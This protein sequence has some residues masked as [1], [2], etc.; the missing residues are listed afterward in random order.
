MYDQLKKLSMKGVMKRLGAGIV[1][2]LIILFVA[3]QSFLKLAKGPQDLYQ[4]TVDQLPNSY[5]E[6]DINVILGAYA[7]YY[8][9]NDDGTEEVTDN[10]YI[11]PVGEEEFVGLAVNKEDF[12]TADQIYNE[13]Y[14]YMMGYRDDLSTSMKV[15]GT[16]NKME[17]DVYEFYEEWFMTSGI[18]ENPTK[19]EFERVALPYVLEID[20]VGKLDTY[21]V[22]LLA[23]LSVILVL[24]MLYAFIA[25]ISGLYLRPVKKYI[26]KHQDL[27]SEE[28]VESDFMNA[29]TI[30]N[31]MVGNTWTF[32][33]KGCKTYMIENKDIVW[34]YL[35]E[36][37]HRVNGIK[38]G[39]SKSL[40]LYNQKKKKLAIPMKKS[41][42]V[43][44]VLGIYSHTQPHMVIGFS[45]ELNKCFNKDFETFLRIPYQNQ[46]QSE[47][48]AGNNSTKNNFTSEEGS[49]STD[50]TN[51]NV[52]T[53]DNYNG[54]SDE[55]YE[56]NITLNKNEDDEE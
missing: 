56:D 22:Y 50:K 48:E 14:D 39:V 35:E 34:A 30:E 41:N 5:V 36:T 4:L 13:T 38:S 1:A 21:I 54:S 15:T 18:L 24:A 44:S 33:T 47:Q 10:Y 40:I 52:T 28:R 7:E 37:T 9:E 55:N 2:L 23:A 19:E 43:N 11:I 53:G 49:S 8:V 51:D 17:D 25:G 42:Y 46:E 12:S 45:E 16:I 20:K 32:Y 26:T 27:V 31:V 29:T 6:G 3:G